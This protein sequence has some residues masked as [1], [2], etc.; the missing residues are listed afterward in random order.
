MKSNT[1]NRD[2]LTAVQAT[3]RDGHIEQAVRIVGCVDYWVA[4]LPCV[5][6][7]VGEK[8]TEFPI[9]V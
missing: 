1:M 4:F 3:S 6:A 7:K 9:L 5:V 2:T 8:S